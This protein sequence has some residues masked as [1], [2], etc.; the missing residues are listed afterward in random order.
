[1][2]NACPTSPSSFQ[3][4]NCQGTPCRRTFVVSAL[5]SQIYVEL[6]SLIVKDHKCCT[7]IADS[8]TCNDCCN[9]RH[10]W[11][12]MFLQMPVALW[13][14]NTECH[15]YISPNPNEMASRSSRTRS[16]FAAT[17]WFEWESLQLGCHTS[18]YTIPPRSEGSR[19]LPCI[20]RVTQPQS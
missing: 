12:C 18:I 16:A 5:C 9:T 13:R 11:A 6:K 19:S 14:Q 7:P 8:K 20:L 1:M 15:P 10:S 4:P 17:M 2:Q 3:S